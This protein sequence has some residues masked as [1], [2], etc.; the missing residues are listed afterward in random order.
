MQPMIDR[1]ADHPTASG[2]RGV[3]NVHWPIA[4]RRTPVRWTGAA[5]A[6]HD[7]R[8]RLTAVPLRHVDVHVAFTA[9]SH[10]RHATHERLQKRRIGHSRI[11]AEH[12]PPV[13]PT[14][15]PKPRSGSGSPVARSV[16]DLFEQ[17]RQK[18]V[19][20]FAGRCVVLVTGMSGTGKST[21]LAELARRGHRVVDTDDPGWIV[22]VE[23]PTALDRVWDVDRVGALLDGHHAG[24]LFVSGCVANQGV[25]YDRFDAVVLLSA[26]VEILLA[27]VLDRANPFGSQPEERARI[28]NDVAAFEPLLRA[29]AGHEIVTTAPIGEVVAALERVATA[30]HGQAGRR[31]Q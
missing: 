12:E 14:N 17:G 8:P 15:R 3:A 13:E 4:W 18:R 30:A 5:V 20:A 16:G 19:T 28:A 22:H 27:R 24:W 9:T 29:G 25:L 10:A 21:A 11:E 1:D 6:E 23:T 7:R 31:S 26:P 2:Q